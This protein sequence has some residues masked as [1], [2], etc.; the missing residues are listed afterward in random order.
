MA[1]PKKKTRSRN[2]TKRVPAKNKRKLKSVP[3]PPPEEDG[4][5]VRA[6]LGGI[7]QDFPNPF[8]S[9]RR[10]L[11]VQDGVLGWGVP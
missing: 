6:T 11:Y 7:E 5:H 8:T 3:P 1:A 4:D 10:Y 9:A 2:S